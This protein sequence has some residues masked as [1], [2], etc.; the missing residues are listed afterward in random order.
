[1]VQTCRTLRFYKRRKCSWVYFSNNNRIFCEQSENELGMGAVEAVM[2]YTRAAIA[3]HSHGCYNLARCYHEGFGV[4]LNDEIALHFFE[5]AAEQEHDL[6]QLSAAICYE[7]AIGCKKDLPKSLKYYLSALNNG[8]RKS[9]VRIMPILSDL[10]QSKCKIIMNAKGSSGFAS[11]PL[12]LRIQILDLIRPSIVSPTQFHIIIHRSKGL[13]NRVPIIDSLKIDYDIY[14]K[15]AC[16]CVS[17][18]NRIC[19]V[20]NALE[21]CSLND[22]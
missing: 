10:L 15:L 20:V 11:L 3:G 8:S 12:E 16:S 1:M 5:K 6:A 17:V 21:I 4:G 18:C 9:L 2:H 7:K 13:T 14:S 22:T 19:H